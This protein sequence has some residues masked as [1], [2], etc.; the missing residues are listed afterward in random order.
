MKVRLTYTVE[1]IIEIPLL[2]GED[3][4]EV[5]DRATQKFADEPEEYLYGGT[6]G[7]EKVKFSFYILP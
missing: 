4:V 2:V 7:E 5:A 3:P 1:R 6:G